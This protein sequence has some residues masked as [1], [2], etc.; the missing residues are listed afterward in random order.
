MKLENKLP[1]EKIRAS[2]SAA[3]RYSVIIFVL[4]MIGIYA[5]V[6]LRI[7]SLDNVQPT[8]NAVTAQNNPIRSARID[9][10]VVSQLQ[11]LQDNSV[12]V[13]TLFSQ[14]RDNPFQ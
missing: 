12:S 1:I 13:Q 11:T 6:L 3:G 8:Q 2:L 14:A 5:F 4:V 9:Q 7:N 10:S